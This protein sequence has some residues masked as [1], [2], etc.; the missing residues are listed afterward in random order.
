MYIFQ[1]NDMMEIN[2][3]SEVLCKKKACCPKNIQ[4]QIQAPFQMLENAYLEKFMFY[5]LKGHPYKEG[6]FEKGGPHRSND[7]RAAPREDVVF[8]GWWLWR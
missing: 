3:D 4:E 7:K 1:K 2:R 6:A 5:F 8:G